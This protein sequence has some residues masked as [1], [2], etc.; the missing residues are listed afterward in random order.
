MTI[1]KWFFIL[2]T[3]LVIYLFWSIIQPFALVLLTAAV[4]AVVISPV[5]R[6]LNKHLKHD[7][8]S[9]AIISVGAIFFVFVPLLAILL[10]M[11][12]QA[13]DIVQNSINDPAWMKNLEASFLP[14]LDLFPGLFESYNFN[15][16]GTTIASWAVENAGS[17]FASTTKLLLNTFFFFI[18]LY[19]ILVD[20]D[21]LYH[22]IVVLS[23]LRDS[24]DK[25]LLK[26]VIKTVRSVVFGVLMLAIVQGI[27]AGIGLTI[28]GVPG[29]LIWGAVTILAALVPL[30]G[31]ALVMI[32][33]VLYLFFT[34]STAAALG[35]LIWSVVFVGMIDN[36]LGPYLIKGTT[37]MHTFLV[38]LAVLGG[39]QT[40][41]YVG[42]IAGPTILASFLALLEIYKSGILSE[43]TKKR[44]KV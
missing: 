3:A 24:I 28:F 8:I 15:Q 21:K 12:N 2:I 4:V 33:A 31:S 41:G 43:E 32:P 26:R 29:S 44:K 30:V 6:R 35:L 20:R 27:F 11:I 40:F 16:I 10:V 25:R 14:L 36:L 1:E 34:G 5:E 17:V 18:A 22:E 42:I 19:Y 13:S 37:N 7:K 9:A 39:I 23:P 38:L